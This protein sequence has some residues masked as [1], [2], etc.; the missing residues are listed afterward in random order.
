MKRPPITKQIETSLTLLKGQCDEIFDF[1]FF[2]FTLYSFWSPLTMHIFSFSQINLYLKL[3]RLEYVHHIPT[4]DW[5]PVQ[6][7]VGSYIY[8]PTA[9]WVGHTSWSIGKAVN[10]NLG[11]NM[12]QG[13]GGQAPYAT[14]QLGGTE[15]RGGKM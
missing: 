6:C 8:V 12:G 15:K 2:Y 5:L 4:V 11:D 14:V 7:T 13:G 1:K 10:V 3:T 9:Q